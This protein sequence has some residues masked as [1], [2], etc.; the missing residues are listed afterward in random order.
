MTNFNVLNNS[1]QI[2]NLVQIMEAHAALGI[3]A[4]DLGD[5]YPGVE[6]TVG[7]FMRKF[8]EGS[9]QPLVANTKFVPNKNM[10]QDIDLDHTR[11]ILRRSCNRLGV[12]KL[13]LVQMHWWDYDVARYVEVGKHL[14]TLQQE[15]LV[16]HIGTTNMDT[17]RIAEMRAAGVPLVVNQAQYSLVDRRPELE[18]LP[19]CVASQVEA[20]AGSMPAIQVLAYGVLCGG[21]LTDNW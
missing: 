1:E 5:I 2:S 3:T 16:A 20:P 7:V 19:L 9:D 17:K 14:V 4:F 11:R 15:D 6:E 13:D 21:F 8:K 18:M 10:L 12:A